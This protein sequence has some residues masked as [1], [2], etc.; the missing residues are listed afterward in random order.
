MGMVIAIEE[1]EFGSIELHRA[2]KYV[3]YEITTKGSLKGHI[4]MLAGENIDGL[5]FID[6]TQGNYF[7]YPPHPPVP[8]PEKLSGKKFLGKI[9]IKN[10]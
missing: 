1:N 6:F 9:V 8:Y 7:I 5:H 2:P 3:L 10:S 4:V